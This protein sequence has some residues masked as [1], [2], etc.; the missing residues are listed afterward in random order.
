[1]TDE[2]YRKIQE[3]CETEMFKA[4]SIGDYESALKAHERSIENMKIYEGDDN[5]HF[6]V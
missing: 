2:E 6:S 1:M 5:D 3:E 4:S